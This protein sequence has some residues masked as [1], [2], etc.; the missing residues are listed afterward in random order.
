MTSARQL[1]H[2]SLA[3]V[4]ISWRESFAYP[5][6]F[7]LGRVNLIFPVIAFAFI[8]KAV[9][10]DESYFSFVVVGMLVAGILEAGIGGLS[11]KLNLEINTGRLEGYLVEPVP[12]WF[13]P[14]GLTIFDLF[15]RIAGAVLMLVLAMALGADFRGGLPMVQASALI[16][17]GLLAVLSISIA[18][19]GLQVVAKRAGTVLSV[20]SFAARFFGGVLFPIDVLPAAIRPISYLFPHTY[21][22]S[23]ARGLLLDDDTIGTATDP[24]QTIVV[25]LLMVA[26]VLPISLW[27]FKR[28]VR[29]GKERG[30]LAGY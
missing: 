14:F 21:V 1:A 20:Y 26:L 30:L 8:S 15:V 25:M 17:L 5:A 19:A 29:Y 23:S 22:V 4:Q 3:F 16:F 11:E 7:I 9:A 18:G 28:A 2:V 13:L 27:T 10:G 24:G 12:T 6:S